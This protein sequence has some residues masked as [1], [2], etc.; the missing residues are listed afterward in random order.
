MLKFSI[1][2]NQDVLSEPEQPDYSWLSPLLLRCH[3]SRPGL[4]SHLRAGL[5]IHLHCQGLGPYGRIHALIWLD[6]F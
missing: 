6:V 1:Q 3:H 5:Q 4:L 2:A